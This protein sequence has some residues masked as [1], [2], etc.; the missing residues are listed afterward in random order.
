MQVSPLFLEQLLL[1]TTAAAAGLM[2]MMMMHCY[3]LA[4]MIE[5]TIT[6]VCQA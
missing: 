4:M 6:Y 5:L 2:M 3:V 1:I